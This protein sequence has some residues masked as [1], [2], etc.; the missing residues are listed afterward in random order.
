MKIRIA[1]P[2]FRVK[3]AWPFV[4]FRGTQIYG[5]NALGL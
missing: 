3:P 5:V 2:I 4:F 1:I